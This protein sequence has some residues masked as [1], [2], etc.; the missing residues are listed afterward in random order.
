MPDIETQAVTQTMHVSKALVAAGHGGSGYVLNDTVTLA[1]GVVLKATTM[2]GGAIASVSIQTAG[3]AN[4]D[5]LPANPV[6]QVST[7]GAGTGAQ[8]ILTW[9]FGNPPL[10]PP[11][12]PPVFPPVLPDT[13]PVPV[14]AGT[15]GGI[16]V[17][18]AAVPPSTPGFPLIRYATGSATVPAANGYFTKFTT[19][20]PAP[21][22]V[23]PVAPSPLPW[24]GATKTGGVWDNK[25]PPSTPSTA[26]IIVSFA[27]READDDAGSIR[28]G[29]T[30][31]AERSA[32]SV[33]PGAD[34][35]HLHQ[36][37]PTKNSRRK[38]LSAGD[39]ARRSDDT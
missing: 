32:G 25:T 26:P 38:R 12:N 10:G 8:F 30:E 28:G 24:N 7:S 4:F 13:T 31:F 37:E 3:S 15:P 18:P 33:F 23:I 27:A 17:A 9:A 19:T 1:N 16:E 6:P 34:T 5:A 39:A 36:S 2:T 35:A 14:P 29:H 21:T 22:I 11:P 20:F